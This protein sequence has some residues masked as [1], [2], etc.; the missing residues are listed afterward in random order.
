LASAG[1]TS[2]ESPSVSQPAKE[3]EP[4]VLRKRPVGV[5]VISAF[6]FL[7]G[8]YDLLGGF[9]SIAPPSQVVTVLYGSTGVWF[10]LLDLIIGFGLLKAKRWAWT[11]A[12]IT[13]PISI[14]TNALAIAGEWGIGVSGDAFFAVP[15]ALFAVIIILYLPKENVKDYFG[16]VSIREELF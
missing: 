5:T 1:N 6:F 7:I 9:A 15:Y 12:L 4:K 2:P 3:P 11:T 13:A 14:I 16:K 8:I 10:G